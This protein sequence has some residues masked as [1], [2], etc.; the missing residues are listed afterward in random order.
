MKKTSILI[1][2]PYL[3]GSHQLWLESLVNHPRWVETF[4]T[5]IL[6]MPARFW[7]W[8]MLG[9]GIYLAEQFLK[10]M[11]KREAGFDLILAS[12]MLDL[13]TF[14]SLTAVSKDETPVALYF[15]ENQLSYPFSPND[16]DVQ[17]NRDHHY[18]FINY[19]SALAADLVSF[20]SF[21]HRRTFLES[22]TVLLKG[23]PDFNQL[24]TIEWIRRKS[25]VLYPCV[26]IPEVAKKKESDRP[27]FLWNH[28]WEYDKNP[29]GFFSLMRALKEG[30]ISFQ[31]I[32]LGE[33][34]RQTPEE[35]LKAKEEFSEEITHWGFEP[36][37]NQYYELLAKADFLPVTSYQDNFG[38]SSVEAILSGVIPLFPSR[39][40]YP[41]LVPDSLHEPLFYSNPEDLFSKIMAMIQPEAKQERELLRK[42]I[43]EYAN[44]F[45]CDSLI[46]TYIR[47]LQR[48]LPRK[49]I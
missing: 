17:K 35:F 48:L 27:T 21:Y 1:I 15:H 29:A 40:S 14:L 28:R 22:A 37:R 4:E 6:S 31:L 10:L 24:E 30:G 2:E 36:D 43:K 16:R 49:S 42:K 47:E 5:D 46:Q 12:D 23:L 41:E 7:K 44:K 25:I 11:K 38:I 34:F 13:N 32:V 20:N 18:G 33:N 45:T 9:S 19:R 3:G 26:N 39:L 8:R